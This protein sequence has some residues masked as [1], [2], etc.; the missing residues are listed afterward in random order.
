MKRR[1]HDSRPA[2]AGPQPRL[3]AGNE[4]PRYSYAPT[5]AIRAFL[6]QIETV[7]NAAEQSGEPLLRYRKVNGIL[8]ALAMQVEDGGDDPAVVAHLLDALESAVR[9][10]VSEPAAS[11]VVLAVQALRDDA[12]QRRTQSGGE[13][14]L[15]GAGC[16][17]ERGKWQVRSMRPWKNSS[18]IK[19]SPQS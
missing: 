19:A 16:R 4:E 2:P 18:D 6:S 14:W 7:R 1:R 15:H 5:P 12:T 11:E 13:A 9:A 10:H 8:N 17:V 3:P